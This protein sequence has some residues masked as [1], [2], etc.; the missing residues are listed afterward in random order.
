MHFDAFF[1]WLPFE[2]DKWHQGITFKKCLETKKCGPPPQIACIYSLI[3]NRWAPNSSPEIE[4]IWWDETSTEA[5]SHHAE[6]LVNLN[7]PEHVEKN[8]TDNKFIVGVF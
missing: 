6:G 5:T 4:L 8:Q 2:N 7:A 1:I 3:I